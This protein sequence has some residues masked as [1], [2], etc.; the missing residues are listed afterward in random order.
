MLIRPRNYKYLQLHAQQ[1]YN[2]SSVSNIG[3]VYT[4]LQS[5]LHDGST[6]TDTVHC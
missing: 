5:C 1:Q 4:N 2:K 6:Y 3:T